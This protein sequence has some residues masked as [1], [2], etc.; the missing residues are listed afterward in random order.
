M[1]HEKLNFNY[2]YSRLRKKILRKFVTYVPLAKNPV[3]PVTSKFFPLKKFTTPIPSF[4]CAKVELAVDPVPLGMTTSFTVLSPW[5]LPSSN[6]CKLPAFTG[7]A[8]LCLL[9][10]NP[11]LSGEIEKVRVTVTGMG[12]SRYFCWCKRERVQA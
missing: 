10:L 11:H 12:H 4:I 6:K 7:A 8:V 2:K 3:A 1:L 9:L 5:I